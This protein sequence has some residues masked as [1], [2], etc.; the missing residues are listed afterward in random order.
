[1]LFRKFA[2]A[3]VALSLSAAPTM[4]QA[5]SAQ[6]LSLTSAPAAS[7]AGASSKGSSALQDE[8]R[9]FMGLGSDGLIIGLIAFA[10][11]LVAIG[12]TVLN[13]DNGSKSP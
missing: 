5:S 10:V 8:D 11:V 7:R 1:M 3:A 6:S 13:D 2:A 12:D 9:G 4:V